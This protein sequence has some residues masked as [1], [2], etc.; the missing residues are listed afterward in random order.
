M[1]YMGVPPAPPLAQDDVDDLIHDEGEEVPEA[2]DVAR[3]YDREAHLRQVACFTTYPLACRSPPLVG[4]QETHACFNG[5]YY[6]V[7][8]LSSC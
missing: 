3:R 5:N 7:V 2:E 8:L 1:F 4:G 6:H